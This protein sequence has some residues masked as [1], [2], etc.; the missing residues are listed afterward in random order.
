MH[1]YQHS[2][3]RPEQPLCYRCE[4]VVRFIMIY[5]YRNV[6]PLMQR[7]ARREP[8]VRW[9]SGRRVTYTCTTTIRVQLRQI[10]TGQQQYALVEVSDLIDDIIVC[11]LCEACTCMCAV[12]TVHCV[13]ELLLTLRA[14]DSIST[15][16]TV[17]HNTRDSA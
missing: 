2:K 9:T 3:A 12:G 6:G 11:G 5:T 13:S 16:A 17:Q 10:I 1:C 14:A 8:H 15:A 7:S 4:T